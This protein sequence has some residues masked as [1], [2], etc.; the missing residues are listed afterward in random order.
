MVSSK[1][2]RGVLWQG[3]AVPYQSVS[4]GGDETWG[5]HSRREDAGVPSGVSNGGGGGSPWLEIDCWSGRWPGVPRR[6]I[7]ANLA[8][9]APAQGAGEPQCRQLCGWRLFFVRASGRPLKTNGLAEAAPTASASPTGQLWL[10][11]VTVR[12]GKGVLEGDGKRRRRCSTEP[13]SAVSLGEA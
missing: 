7:A 1:P 11:P 3:P 6:S 12:H 8:G 5:E 9:E 10:P 2:G 4:E 13:P